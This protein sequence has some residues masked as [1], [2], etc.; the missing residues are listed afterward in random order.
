MADAH[1]TIEPQQVRLPLVEERLDI[2]RSL[3]EEGRVRAETHVDSRDIAVDETLRGTRVR[4]ER[5]AIDR[6]VDTAPPPR[7]ENGRT[8]LSVVEEVLVKRLRVV[9]EVHLIEEETEENVHATVTLRRSNVTVMRSD[10]GGA[11]WTE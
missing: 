3:I 11:T 1:E 6:V 8:I 4:V 9:E 2:S 7:V 10:D 5:H